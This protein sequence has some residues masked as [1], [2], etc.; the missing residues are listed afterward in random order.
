M[1]FSDP[2]FWVAV[3]FIIFVALVF[4]AGK[5]V[6]VGM[7]DSR[8]DAIRDSLDQ[9]AKLREEAQQLLAEYQRKQRD[10]VKD[11]ED[12]VARAREDAARISKEGA[13]KLE[14]A[15]QRREQM[16]MEKIA[17]AEADAVREV[18]TM[19]VEVAVSATRNLIAGRMD[20]QKAGA[21]VDDAISDLSNK[22]H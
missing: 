14:E 19:S 6:L 16:A 13:A 12:L 2:T 4:R 11:T 10:A 22:L 7:L 21:L 9:A 17:Q 8:A 3:G 20:S 18:R 5:K 15:M 1:D